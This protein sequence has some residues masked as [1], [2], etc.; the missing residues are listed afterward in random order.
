[1]KGKL[2]MKSGTKLISYLSS[3]FTDIG[4][5]IKQMAKRSFYFFIIIEAIA[6]MIYGVI[7]F[8]AGAWPVGLLLIFFG[9]F[10]A[11]LINT[12]FG[13]PFYML[14]YGFGE[15]V[16]K[17]I[18]IENA[19]SPS[20]TKPIQQAQSDANSEKK[21]KLLALRIKGAISEEEYQKAIKETESENSDELPKL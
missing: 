16:D 4:V 15:L 13:A 20:D 10:A 18:H 11:I 9:P 19:I 3:Y 17:A 7:L 12:T 1:M 6:A 8:P 5:K 14:I 2:K 21:K